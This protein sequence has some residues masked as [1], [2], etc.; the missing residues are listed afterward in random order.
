MSSS[1]KI[2]PAIC[3]GQ[4]TPHWAEIDFVVFWNFWLLCTVIVVKLSKAVS[5][6][7]LCSNALFA[8]LK[9]LNIVPK[10]SCKAFAI[11]SVAFEISVSLL[12]R[13]IYEVKFSRQMSDFDVGR[14]ILLWMPPFGLRNQDVLFCRCMMVWYRCIMIIRVPSCVIFSRHL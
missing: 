3:F 4:P 1:H 14:Q 9:W 11:Q 10:M 6:K 13:S 8:M 5:S 7:T 12:T 2:A